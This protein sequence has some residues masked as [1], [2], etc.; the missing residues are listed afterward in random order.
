MFGLAVAVQIVVLNLE[1]LAEGNEDGEGEVI[2]GLI[3][4]TDLATDQLSSQTALGDQSGRK[5]TTRIARA[6]GR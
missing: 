1:V 3:S 4:D 6:T 5:L 2:S